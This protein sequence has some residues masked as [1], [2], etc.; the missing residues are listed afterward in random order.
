[1]KELQA[2]IHLQSTSDIEQHACHQKLPRV[3]VQVLLNQAI[4]TGRRVPQGLPGVN[5][6][7]QE[8]PSLG[9]LLG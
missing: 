2:V 6:R 8:G 7:L 4:G 5:P 9:R 1:M 3:L